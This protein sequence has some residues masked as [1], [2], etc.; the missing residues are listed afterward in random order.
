MSTL[1]FLTDLI[2]AQALGDHLTAAVQDLI[3]REHLERA[4]AYR[5]I[6]DAA[7]SRRPD[8]HRRHPTDLGPPP[9]RR[10]RRG[11][12]QAPVHPGAHPNRNLRRLHRH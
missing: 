12:R 4:E 10:P 1:E 11:P 3:E 6:T 8:R 7:D 2:G 9:R 5:R